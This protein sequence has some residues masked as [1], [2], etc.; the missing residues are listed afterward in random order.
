MSKG[1]IYRNVTQERGVMCEWKD[2]RQGMMKSCSGKA[3]ANTAPAYRRQVPTYRD[4][5]D[6][7]T[8]WTRAG[9]WGTDS[10]RGYDTASPVLS[11]GPTSRDGLALRDIQHTVSAIYSLTNWLLL[12]LSFI[13]PHGAILYPGH[14]RYSRCICRKLGTPRYSVWGS[15]THSSHSTG[16]LS[17][18]FSYWR[19]CISIS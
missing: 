18:V 5:E 12:G 15:Q 17:S 14:R 10:Q 7:E 19:V 9:S 8:Q 1:V 4:R 6:E 16:A 2:G 13:I 11:M 3:R